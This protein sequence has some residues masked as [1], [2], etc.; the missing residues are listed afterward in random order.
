MKKILFMLATLF[1]TAVPAQAM[2]YKTARS[3][4][5]F[6]TD[7]MAYELKLTPA[8]RNAVYEINLDYMM[9]LNSSA[10]AYGAYWTYR[11]LDLG[12]VLSNAQYRMF[13]AAEYFF[14]PVYWKSGWRHHIH[15]RYT[16]RS[17]F[18]YAHPTGYASYKGAHSWHKNGN[19]SWYKGR[20]FNNGKHHKPAICPP[21]KHKPGHGHAKP[22]KHPHKANGKYKDKHNKRNNERHFRH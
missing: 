7:K 14:R 2:S 15:T 6:L 22:A 1:I 17:H 12:Y 9:A 5:L 8:Q 20:K 19:K 4:A 10:D 11:N 16:N 21:N 18:Y 3:E 13:R